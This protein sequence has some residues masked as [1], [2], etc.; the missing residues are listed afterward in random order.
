MRIHEKIYIGLSSLMLLASLSLVFYDQIGVYFWRSGNSTIIGFIFTALFS[1]L[2]GILG[3]F[4]IMS[5]KKRE[6]KIKALVLTTLSS[7]SYFVLMLLNF[8]LIKF[9]KIFWIA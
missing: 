5:A 3:I 2:L 6:E 7:V 9:F 4:F 1:L 8:I